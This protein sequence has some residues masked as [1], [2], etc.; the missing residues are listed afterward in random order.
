[1]SAASGSLANRLLADRQMQVLF[2]HP[3]SPHR[4]VVWPLDVETAIIELTDR[5]PEAEFA[6]I[7]LAHRIGTEAQAHVLSL[8]AGFA[9]IIPLIE[10]ETTNPPS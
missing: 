9:E 4:L 8:I 10:F 5:G 2:E 1:M 3:E 7:S 6:Q